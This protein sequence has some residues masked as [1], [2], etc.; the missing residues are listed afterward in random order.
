MA[1]NLKLLKFTKATSTHFV[2]GYFKGYVGIHI[3]ISVSTVDVPI[4]S[5]GARA[6]FIYLDNT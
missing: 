1:F 3:I 4:E 5:I 6:V 2:C